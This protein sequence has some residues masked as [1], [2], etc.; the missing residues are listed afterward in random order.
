[1]STTKLS[2]VSMSPHFKPGTRDTKKW[3]STKSWMHSEHRAGPFISNHKMNPKSSGQPGYFTD[4]NITFGDV[5]QLT[6]NDIIVKEQNHY[7]RAKSGTI[8]Q[9]CFLPLKPWN[10]CM[11]LRPTWQKY[12][13]S[14]KTQLNTH[15]HPKQ[16]WEWL[17]KA[18]NL[19]IILR[20]CLKSLEQKV[21]FF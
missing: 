14:L 1:M 3:W 2:H 6:K 9:C 17:L 13:A 15:T 4:G 16:K 7:P 21:D 5:P 8:L 10:T 11:T 19:S 20:S 18:F 12:Q